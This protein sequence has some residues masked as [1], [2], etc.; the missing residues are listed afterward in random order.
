MFDSDNA[1]HKKA[2]KLYEIIEMLRD[3]PCTSKELSQ[4]LNI[5]QRSV[6]RCLRDL[7][8]LQIGL[9]QG[10]N[11][12]GIYTYSLPSNAEQLNEVE[13]LITH[14][15][16]RMLYHHATSPNHHYLR[17]LEKL[18]SKLSEPV[19]STLYRSTLNL[20]QRTSPVP[21]E[22]R[23][24][25][26][27]ARAWFHGRV[28]QFD[29]H[30]PS[31]PGRQK[32]ELEVYF[33]EVSRSNLA[34][35]VIGYE[36][37]YHQKVRTFKL[38]RMQNATVQPTTYTIPDSFDPREYLSGAWG[39]IGAHSGTPVQVKLRFDAE[40]TRRL[41]EGGHPNLTLTHEFADGSSI[42]TIRVGTDSEGFPREILPWVLSWGSKVQVLEPLSLRERC[43]Q[44]ALSMISQIDP[45]GACSSVQPS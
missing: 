16:V 15:A 18:A 27:I 2:R 26:T 21:D 6:Q 29:Y 32:Y 28:V 36:R 4:R 3:R 1:H 12:S 30:S 45:G 24:L 10:K 43:L 37:K 33:V 41:Q 9:R 31:G 5:S 19:R 11:I 34:T 35:Y 25:E 8:D 22:G 44:E 13:A 39:V 17:V 14:N 7:Q 23:T 20:K 38:S 40:A 42:A